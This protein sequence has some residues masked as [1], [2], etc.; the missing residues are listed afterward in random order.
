M[1]A[2]GLREP[3]GGAPWGAAPVRRS[4]EAEASEQPCP[5][6]AGDAKQPAKP[7]GYSC[8]PPA[9]NLLREGYVTFHR[10]HCG[11]QEEQQQ[12]IQGHRRPAAPR[13]SPRRG[14]RAGRAPR[15]GAPL[16][17]PL[18][19]FP[20]PFALSLGPDS[21]E[22][23][24]GVGGSVRAWGGAGARGCGCACV[25]VCLWER[26]VCACVC[27]RAREC[28]LERAREC[29]CVLLSHCELERSLREDGAGQ[30]DGGG[31]GIPHHQLSLHP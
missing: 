4:A 17:S 5:R 26:W 13:P 29:V 24:V 19:A 31:N 1:G 12:A 9:A 23:G 25:C 3:A 21:P 7:R 2:K 22:R 15:P 18:V 11:C 27:E 28:E 14:G 8:Q 30:T 6:V 16:H 20:Y 10:G